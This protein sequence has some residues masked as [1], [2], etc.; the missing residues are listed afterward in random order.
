MSCASLT[1]AGVIASERG[2]GPRKKKKKEKEK[3][4]KGKKIDV[5]FLAS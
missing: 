4:R 5:R 3:K 2:D 1:C